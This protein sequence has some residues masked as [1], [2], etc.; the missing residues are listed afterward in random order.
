MFGL[1]RLAAPGGK[2]SVN[3]QNNTGVTALAFCAATGCTAE[4]QELINCG[5]DVNLADE[6]GD[7][8]LVRAAQ[9]S[10]DIGR[11]VAK[12]LLDSGADVNRLN[13]KKETPLMHA[14]IMSNVSV[15]EL[16]LQRGA[17]PNVKDKDFDDIWLYHI[18]RAIRSDELK[19][20][21]PNHKW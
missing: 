7:V 3:K 15:V 8:P 19:A 1:P 11:A 12:V 14:C 6:D 13:K 18:P 17:D 5:A 9:A 4:A 16:L 10:G 20:L 2:E 21:F